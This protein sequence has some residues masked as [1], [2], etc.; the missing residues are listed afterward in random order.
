MPESL[1]M[2]ADLYGA[3]GYWVLFLGVMLESAGVPLPGETALL[4]AAF[5]S[6]PEAGG[7]LHLEWVIVVATVAAIIGDNVGY[8]VG[9]DLARARIMQG[10]RFL[11]ITP[12]RVLR[13]EAYFVRYGALTVF[14]GRFVALLR[15]MAGPA[16]GVAGMEWR[17]F[18]LANATGAVVWATAIG[19]LGYYAGGAW[20]ALHH[21]LGRGAWAMAG[22]LALVVVGWHFVPYLV[23]R[24]P[25]SAVN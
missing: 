5:L 2:F 18:F 13:A 19:L 11:F 1:Q 12:G 25:E 17:R 9:R 6:S 3:H 10:K 23:K 8:W 7:R 14:F 15:I 16:A 24:K 21:W 4:A 20:D 22:V